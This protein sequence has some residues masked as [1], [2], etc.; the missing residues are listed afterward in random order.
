MSHEKAHKS[1]K[2]LYLLR[3][4]KSSWSDGALRDF[5]RPLKRRGREAAE[6]IGERLG[7]EKLN[8]PLVICSPASRTRETA[9]IILQRAELRVEE[10]FEERIYEASLRDLVQVVAEIPDEKQIAILIGHN[11]G[12]EELLT[13]FTSESR[14]MPTCALA[15][16]Q[17]DVESWK[18]VNAGKGSLEWLITPKELLD[19]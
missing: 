13:F 4:A 18:D 6:R 14:R 10:R 17:L 12:L 19:D 11:P 15:K 2:T 8:E 3:H 1:A 7:L 9:E 16:I 5:D